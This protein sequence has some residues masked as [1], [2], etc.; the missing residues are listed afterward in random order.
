MSCRRSDVFSHINQGRFSSKKIFKKARQ[1][2][3]IRAKRGRQV[4]P[5][6]QKKGKCVSYKQGLQYELQVLVNESAKTVREWML[7]APRQRARPRN[8]AGVGF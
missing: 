6:K 4:K 8:A 2:P 1:L 3:T 7:Q 5:Q